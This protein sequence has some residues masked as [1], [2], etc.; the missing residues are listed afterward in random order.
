MT[1]NKIPTLQ[2]F[3]TGPHSESGLGSYPL[4]AKPATASQPQSMDVPQPP[5]EGKVTEI[6]QPG[7]NQ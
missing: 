2:N 4:P 1:D 3:S 6:I 7:V 5:S